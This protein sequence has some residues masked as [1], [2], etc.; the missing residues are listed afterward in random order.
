MLFAVMLA[1]SL[2]I[3]D[4]ASL[5]TLSSP[6][7]SPDGERV[8]YVVTRAEM[9]RSVYVPEVRVIRADGSDDRLFAHPASTPR[10]SPDGKWLAFLSDR[11][12]RNA[13]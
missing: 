12:G 13:I 4:Y 10:W 1:T 7:V 2:S 5:P 6:R 8:A 3:S 9:T 11:D